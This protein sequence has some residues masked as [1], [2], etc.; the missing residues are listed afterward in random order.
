M[1]VEAHCQLQRRKRGLDIAC[2]VKAEAPHV[3]EG[4]RI[5]LKFDS[6]GKGLSSAVELLATAKPCSKIGISLR[7]GLALETRLHRRR[8]GAGCMGE[9]CCQQAK[10]DPHHACR[11]RDMTVNTGA[12]RAELGWDHFRSRLSSRDVIDRCRLKM[13]HDPDLKSRDSQHGSES[14]KCTVARCSVQPIAEAMYTPE[15][16]LGG[17]AFPET[18]LPS[19]GWWRSASRKSRDGHQHR[20]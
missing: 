20:K 18:P 11:Q 7:G 2:G 8:G 15:A 14:V 4:R 17:S 19:G 12:R 3:S 16:G 1:R 6:R 5:R 13:A 9:R 10:Q